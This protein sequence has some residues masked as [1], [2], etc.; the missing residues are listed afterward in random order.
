[1]WT[2]YK[3]I[4]LWYDNEEVPDEFKAKI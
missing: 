3:T 4:T 2:K 1:M